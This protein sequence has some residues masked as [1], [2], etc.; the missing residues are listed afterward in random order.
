MTR[1]H[2]KLPAARRLREIFG[3]PCLTAQLA[4]ISEVNSRMRPSGDYEPRPV[5]SGYS[6]LVRILPLALGRIA[7]DREQPHPRVIPGNSAWLT[8]AFPN[9]VVAG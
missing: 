9:A 1:R 8:E 2:A 7:I 5:A 3:F 6:F 4:K